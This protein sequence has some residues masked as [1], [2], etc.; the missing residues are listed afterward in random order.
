MQVYLHLSFKVGSS[1]K[2]TKIVSEPRT[3]FIKYVGFWISYYHCVYERAK[4]VSIVT[5]KFVIP[6]ICYKSILTGLS[7]NPEFT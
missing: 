2:S 7:F 3:S 6:L 4:R 1:A 5:A